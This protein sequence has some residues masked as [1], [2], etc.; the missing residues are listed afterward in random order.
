MSSVSTRQRVIDVVRER[1]EREPDRI[2][3]TFHKPDGPAESLTYEALVR[4]ACAYARAL[5]AQRLTAGS[6]VVVTAPTAPQF[7]AA[8]LGIQQAGLIPIPA[9]P[10]E[11]L[12]GAARYR[13]RLLDI[14]ERSRAAA[15]V[16]PAEPPPA[17]LQDMLAAGG[18]ALVTAQAAPRGSEMSEWA[19]PDTR[20]AYCQFTS[21]S[22]GRAKGV[23]LTHE[24]VFANIRARQEAY[25]LRDGDVGVS[26]LPLSHDMGLVGYILSPLM[27]GIP[28]HLMAPA[29]FLADPRAWLALITRVR[30]TI[31]N[32]PNSAYGLC[33][34]RV[35]ETA[36]DGLE[37]SSW[38]RAFNGAEPVT[39]E[40]VEAFVRRF[41][42]VGFRASAMLP[43]YG[44]AENTLSVA[45]RRAGQG[46]H[47]D[48]I[49]RD[50]LERLHR[51]VP[52]G[53]DE[54]RLS[55]ASVGVPL[56]GQ[57][58]TIRDAGGLPCP[59]R[60]IGEVTI[61]SASVMDGYLEGTEG[62]GGV[63]PEGWLWTG[64][65]GYLADGELYV[66]G[67]KKD[68]IIRA[69]RKYYPQDLEDAIARVPGVR[70]GRVA[71]FAVP[72]AER[73]RVVVVAEHR[74]APDEA[75]ALPA[76]IDRAVFSAV[77]F[78]PDDIVLV[79]PQTLPLTTSGKL[80]RPAVRRTYLDAGYRRS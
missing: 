4:D 23:M 35:P 62:E 74:A 50:V 5:R 73:E 58:V 38:R 27:T 68:L 29:A 9:P 69:G 10:P 2:C 49:D 67:R 43:G 60:C 25:G 48:V 77:R 24:N 51:A 47:F 33:V 31:A 20:I 44:L 19:E 34:R 65:L 11:P 72:G 28:C 78:R 26:W 80:M 18:V 42:K 53:A 36:L 70:S 75:A 66:V 54:P 1:A 30:G 8:F 14:V 16:I 17:D 6:M 45:S 39:G 32:A 61:R 76:L 63:D 21:G 7:V 15:V 41:E 79:A 55:V 22:G 13:E 37:L 64:D 52:A 40:V 57:E 46:A 56:P 71:A 3:L 12:S 59:E